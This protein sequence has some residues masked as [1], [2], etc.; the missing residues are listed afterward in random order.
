MEI[1]PASPF[2]SFSRLFF[3]YLSFSSIFTRCRDISRRAYRFAF[4]A[5]IY[6]RLRHLL[7]FCFR[8]PRHCQISTMLRAGCRR[9]RACFSPRE[10]CF[11]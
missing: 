1:E 4:A 11:A 10:R 3:D 6:R 9:F 2:S 5:A 7:P 8:L